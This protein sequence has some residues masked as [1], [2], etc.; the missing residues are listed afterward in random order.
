M[1]L[2]A[3]LGKMVW[4]R[5]GFLVAAAL[6][7]LFYTILIPFYLYSAWVQYVVVKTGATAMTAINGR[8]IAIVMLWAPPIEDILI[9]LRLLALVFWLSWLWSAARFAWTLEPEKR[10]HFYPVATL[11]L[12]FVPVINVI[13]MPLALND[14]ARTV[15]REPQPAS[16]AA[17]LTMPGKAD[18][19]WLSGA[20]GLLHGASDAL[21]FYLAKV[22]ISDFQDPL[23]GLNLTHA[24]A[25]IGVV[26]LLMLLAMDAYIRK[27]TLAQE[28]RLA[29]RHLSGE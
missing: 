15:M 10:L 20:I 18:M 16:D 14:I 11:I 27:L 29:R 4:Y 6:T 19:L 13:A 3:L 25:G 28:I 12:W 7:L 24:A 5:R 21:F 1:Q 2:E 26:T 22:P 23:K 8:L 9:L 17:P